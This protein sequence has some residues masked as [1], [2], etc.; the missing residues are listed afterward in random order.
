MSLTLRTVYQNVWFLST[1]KPD[2]IVFKPVNYKHVLPPIG[3]IVGC[4]LHITTASG[5]MGLTPAHRISQVRVLF[6]EMSESCIQVVALNETGFQSCFITM[7][8]HN[9]NLVDCKL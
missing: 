1:Q 5:C 3:G 7:Y 6:F 4:C 8:L 9:M 2:R